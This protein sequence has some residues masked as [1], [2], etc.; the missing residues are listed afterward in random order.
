MIK[1]WV[2]EQQHHRPRLRR[3][4]RSVSFLGM[5]LYKHQTYTHRIRLALLTAS[6]LA[7]RICPSFNNQTLHYWGLLTPFFCNTKIPDRF[8]TQDTRTQ[9][10]VVW[11]AKP[12]CSITT[13]ART[14]KIS[15]TALTNL[16]IS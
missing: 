7:Q 14:F 12:R 1:S 2:L 10:R 15:D 13:Q 8:A 11:R 3:G 16:P 6:N 4:R 5:V 9:D